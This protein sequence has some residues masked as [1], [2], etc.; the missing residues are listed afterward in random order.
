MDYTNIP[1][2]LKIT[3]Q[4]PL[5]QKEWVQNE[6]TL[7]DL[8][9]NDE[10]AFTYYEHLEVLCIDEKTLYKWKEVPSGEEDT[11]LL[12]QDFIY[13]AG[14]P[15]AFGINYS[16]RRFN[17]FLIEYVTSENIDIYVENFV[18][19]NNVGN[20]AK[21]YKEGTYFD[22]KTIVSDNLTI[23][24]ETDV[25]RINSSES[26]VDKQITI[27]GNVT[28]DN[29]Y[30][31]K[32]VKIKSTS[33]ITIPAGLNDEFN[34]VFRTYSGVTATFIAGVGVTL[35][36]PHGLVLEEFKMTTLFKDGNLET[37]IVEGELIP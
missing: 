9:Y 11:G 14:L 28:L 23:T 36:A 33:N 21:I 15:D 32:I 31:G 8:G 1:T 24:E 10:K 7:Q 37:F 16:N 22:I 26:V 4:L 20:G 3:S 19:I 17:F 5:D 29:T 2:G 30:D 34:C 35:D 18:I 13:P 27:S 25:I 12:I 6:A